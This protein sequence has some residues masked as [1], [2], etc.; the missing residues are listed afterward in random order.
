MSAL[1]TVAKVIEAVLNRGDKAKANAD[2][3]LTALYTA[4]NET[5]LYAGHLPK[6]GRDQNEE[7]QLSRIWFKAAMA[8]RRY[9]VELADSCLVHGE[10]WAYPS[11][12]VVDY[13][14]KHKEEMDEVFGKLRQLMREM[15]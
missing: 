2:E 5:L 11:E 8:I 6:T 9:D 7:D 3:S 14:L 1:E 10:Y 4:L 13:A 12:G 15:A